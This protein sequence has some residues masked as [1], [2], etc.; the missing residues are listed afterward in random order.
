[1]GIVIK[2]FEA[3]VEAPPPT[4]ARDNERGNEESSA[5]RRCEPRELAPALRTLAEQAARVWAH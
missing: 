5:A 1:M 3:V 4:P 2:E